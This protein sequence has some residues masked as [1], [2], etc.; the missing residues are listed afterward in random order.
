M[1]K[2]GGGGLH[3]PARV[4]INCVIS[5]NVFLSEGGCSSDELSEDE[6]FSHCGRAPGVL[7][8]RI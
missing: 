4:C 8:S 1:L 5:R 2:P 3:A 6:R 7:Q